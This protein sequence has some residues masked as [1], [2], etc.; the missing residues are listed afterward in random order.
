M[1]NMCRVIL[2]SPLIFYNLN[3]DTPSEE[4]EKSEGSEESEVSE[5]S[6][7]SESP[8]KKE[9]FTKNLVKKLLQ[10]MVTKL[11][12]LILH[13]HFYKHKAIIF[14]SGF[15]SDINTTQK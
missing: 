2:R 6:E 3:Y 15:F 5:G 1:H 9:N 8:Q 4:S 14:N 11:K 10:T 13:P 12:A 7:E